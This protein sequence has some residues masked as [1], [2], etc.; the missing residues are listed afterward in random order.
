MMHTE[1]NRYYNN[2]NNNQFSYLELIIIN[3]IKTSVSRIF[4]N[5]NFYFIL[6]IS[7]VYFMKNQALQ[8][9]NL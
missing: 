1:K 6:I 8:L 5:N 4:S 3:I 2:K 7:S 9:Q